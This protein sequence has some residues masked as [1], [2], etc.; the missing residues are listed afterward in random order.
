M[1]EVHT[2]TNTRERRQTK[3]SAYKHLLF[4]LDRTLWDFDANSKEAIKEIYTHFQLYHFV[5][6][7]DV[8][9]AKYRTINERL[10]LA[11]RNQE[12]T[13]QELVDQ[14]FYLTFK[15]F[16]FDNWEAGQEAGQMYLEL[17]AQKTHLF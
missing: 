15:T 10:W 11:Y 17:S 5:R 14:R 6:N 8:F 3:R 2:K 12:V 16:G 13:K 7:F 9:L 4:D 1:S